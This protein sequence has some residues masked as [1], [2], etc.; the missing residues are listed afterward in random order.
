MTQQNAQLHRCLRWGK[1]A[2]HSF[3][4]RRNVRFGFQSL[5]R[6]SCLFLFAVAFPWKHDSWLIENG[7]D[8]V[9]GE[10]PPRRRY[11]L[12]NPAAAARWQWRNF[13]PSW[14]TFFSYQA[15]RGPGKK[16]LLSGF[17]QAHTHKKHL[18]RGESY[19]VCLHVCVSGGFCCLHWLLGQVSC[20]VAAH[21]HKVFIVKA[22]AAI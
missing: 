9:L 4:N 21:A 1:S 10:P 16:T 14:G 2:H 3:R 22:P 7:S 8:G 17:T 6:V 19:S 5:C 18:S 11:R 15:A 20:H 12:W 13:P